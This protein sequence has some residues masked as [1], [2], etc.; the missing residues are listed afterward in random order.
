MS[1]ERPCDRENDRCPIIRS[2]AFRLTGSAGSRNLRL[3]GSGL[4]NVLVGENNSGKTSVLEA[5]SVLCDPFNPYEWLSVVYRRDFGGL[6]E[7]RVQSLRWCFQQHG[8]LKDFEAMFEGECE[9]DLHRPVSG[10]ANF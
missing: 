1:D 4:I 3:T 7:N 9:H 8:E 5:M 10:A 6:D 2:K